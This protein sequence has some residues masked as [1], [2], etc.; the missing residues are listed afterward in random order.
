MHF[1]GKYAGIT[2]LSIGFTYYGNHSIRLS[3]NGYITVVGTVKLSPPLYGRPGIDFIAENACPFVFRDTRSVS[4]TLEK[5]AKADA[6]EVLIRTR[7]LKE[8]FKRL[9]SKSSEH[10]EEK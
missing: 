3:Y 5:A 1:D 4:F 10:D 2:P 8:S 9:K 6:D 7:R